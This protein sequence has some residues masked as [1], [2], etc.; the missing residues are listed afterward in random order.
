MRVM[1][2][3]ALLC[4][5]AGCGST[6]TYAPQLSRDEQ[7]RMMSREYSG[8]TPEEVMTAAEKLFRLSDPEDYVFAYPDERSMVATRGYVMFM[9]IAAVSGHDIWSLSVEPMEAGAK[10]RVQAATAS[11]GTSAMPVGGIAVPYNIAGS[12]GGVPMLEPALYGLFWARMDYLLGLRSDWIGCD[13]ARDY[14]LSN[15]MHGVYEP[16]C[17]KM[18]DDNRP[19]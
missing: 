9:V 19:D 7:L 13:Q 14:L 10:L 3:G 11:T 17:G 12:S 8:K 5:L 6:G 4:A 1:I 16:L 15:N 2:L 18:Q